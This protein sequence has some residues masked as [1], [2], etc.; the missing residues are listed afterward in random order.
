MKKLITNTILL[1]L[2]FIAVIVLSFLIYKGNN[3]NLLILLLVINLVWVVIG[4]KDVLKCLEDDN[5]H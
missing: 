2:N 1:T 5:R 3:N 4:V